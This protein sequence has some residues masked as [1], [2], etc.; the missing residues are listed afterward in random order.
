MICNR[1]IATGRHGHC[2]LC[3]YSKSVAPTGDCNEDLVQKA[4]SLRSRVTAEDTPF[5]NK[6]WN[7]LFSFAYC[8]FYLAYIIKQF[9]DSGRGAMYSNKGTKTKN[10]SSKV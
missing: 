7:K 5:I 1:K 2:H 8:Y 4:V 10:V 6:L 9:K 3:T